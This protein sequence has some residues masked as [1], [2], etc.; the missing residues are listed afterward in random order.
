MTVCYGFCAYFVIID[1]FD[2][3]VGIHGFRKPKIKGS[4]LSTRLV[5]ARNNHF[6][7]IAAAYN[8]EHRFSKIRISIF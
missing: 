8:F 3:V 2:F 4:C 6:A 5:A 7:C 1:L